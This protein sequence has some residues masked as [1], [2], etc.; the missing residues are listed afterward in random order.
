MHVYYYIQSVYFLFMPGVFALI[1]AYA[2][3]KYIQS[4]M[5]KEE[6]KYL[7]FLAVGGAAA[8]VF[9]SVIGLTWAGRLT[10]F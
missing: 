10:S 1:N 8:I 7:F 2:V 9:M 4:F 5:T 6:F 3:L